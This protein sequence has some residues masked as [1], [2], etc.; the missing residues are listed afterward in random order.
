MKTMTKNRFGPRALVT[1]DSSGIGEAFARRLGQHG[2][3]M[4]DEATY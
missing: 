1:G 2:G 3:V 4:Q